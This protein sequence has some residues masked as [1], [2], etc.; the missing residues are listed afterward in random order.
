MELF[1]LRLN[2]LLN[3]LKN[4]N[5]EVEKIILQGKYTLNYIFADLYNPP[6][7]ELGIFSAILDMNTMEL[8]VYVS[9]LEYYRVVEAYSRIK[10][11]IVHPVAPLAMGIEL[12]TKVIDI[13][14]MRNILKKICRESRKISID[15]IDVCENDVSVR[16][17][18]RNIVRKVRRNKTE[19]EVDVIRR[20]I[21]ITERAIEDTISRLENGFN[22]Q[23][24]A[25]LLES[26]ARELGAEGFAF[27]TIVAIESNTSKPHHIPSSTMFRG[28]EPIIIDFG[29]R[30]HGYVSDI[31]RTILPSNL[32][33]EYENMR[34]YANIVSDAID[35]SILYLKVGEKYSNIDEI[36]RSVLMKSNIHKYFVHNLGHGIGVDVHEEPRISKA[37]DHEVELGDVITIEPGIYIRGKFGIRIEDDVHITPSG[38]VK[39]TSLKRVIEL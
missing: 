27:S 9:S 26:R 29:V 28:G 7:E 23:I 17:D 25:G 13:S 19:E 34:E 4:F 8:D 11:L 18:I 2:K 12:D 31:T 35:D 30:I 5:V 16:I 14:D 38:P 6:P 24:I 3:A 15:S 10:N 36:A 39:L 32:Q 21:R 20:A 33:K 22:E 37:S 1:K